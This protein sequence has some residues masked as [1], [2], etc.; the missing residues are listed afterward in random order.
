MSAKAFKK[1][2]IFKG[3]IINIDGHFTA[4]FGKSKIGKDKHAT[5]NIIMH[6]IKAFISQ[7]QE[8]GNPI[9]VQVA[10]PRKGITP[11]NVTIPM[12]EITREIIP[13]LEKVVFDKWFSVGSLIEYIDK[14]M[15]L[16]YI[17]L[18]KHYKNRIEEMK[19]VA[20]NEFKPLIGTD[21]LIGFKETNLRNF[22]GNMKLIIVRFFEDGIENYYGYLT[23]DYEST[24]EQ[25]LKE[26]SWRWRIENFIKDCNFLGINAL[27]S[28]ELNKIAAMLA[29]KIFALNLIA[30]MR[31]D[32]GGDFEKM[33]VESVFE[34]RIQFPAFI[35]VNGD[36][37]IITFFGN[38]KDKQKDA[39]LKLMK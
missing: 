1:L 24:G 36:K 28:I 26:K 6:G 29:I 34:E 3:K 32:I 25:I 22:S 19:S 18:I 39:V 12:L 2:G 10:Y 20:I 33:N 4:Y 30:C 9:F 37:I 5:R 13:E 21:Q 31:K 8:T 14:K 17:T 7:D 11:E 23:N 27:P 15:K 35:K 38:Y 16:K